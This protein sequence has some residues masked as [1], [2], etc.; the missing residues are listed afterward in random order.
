M[1][2]SSNKEAR[3]SFD[4]L[5]RFFQK[6]KGPI[7]VM[8]TLVVLFFLLKDFNLVLLA[9]SFKHSRKFVLIYSTATMAALSLAFSALRL[10]QTLKI[11]GHNIGFKEAF[12]INMSILPASKL[13]PANSGDMARSFFLKGKVSF[14]ANTGGIFF[15]RSFD[16][17]ILSVISLVGSFILKNPV[18]LLTSGGVM[19]VS[20]TFFYIIGKNSF[21]AKLITKSNKADKFCRIFKLFF[22][23]PK[24]FFGIFLYT[25]MIWST[26]LFYVKFLFYSFGQN[27]SF[28]EISSLQP[29]VS[30]ASF[31]PITVSGIGLREMAMLKLYSGLSPEYVILSVGFAYSFLGAF[32]LP[33][34][35]TPFMYNFIRS[36]KAAK[37]EQNQSFHNSAGI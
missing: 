26:A 23:Q 13:S 15:E 35:G 10:R 32:V 3:E 12:K 37:N 4:G 17:L 19:T 25:L 16:V 20:L 33:L 1:N 27:I 7:V 2:H 30:F 6:A 5:K 11:L 22:A 21:F 28:L 24:M 18:G 8:A 14:M 31:V 9:D 36:K 29:I 34:L